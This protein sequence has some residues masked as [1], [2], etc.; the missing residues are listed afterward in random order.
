MPKWLKKAAAV[1]A[2]AV[3]AVAAAVVISAVAPAA[4][5]SLTIMAMN[6]GASYAVAHVAA[7]TVVAATSVAATAYAADDAYAA[8][9]GESI[10]LDTVFAGNVEAYNTGRDI[11]TISTAGMLSAAS[12]SP[13]VCFVDG[14]AVL[15]D[16]G[17]VNI[18][19]IAPGDMVWAWN[20]ET[21]EV[22]LKEVIETY[23][24]QTGE[25]VHIF[26]N[27]EEIVCTPSHPFYSPVKG[28]TDAVHLRAGDILVL[29]NGEYVVIEKVQ[30]EIL[31]EPIAVY[32]FQVEDFHTYYVSDVGVLVHNMCAKKADIKQVKN[33]ARE[34]GIPPEL[35]HDFG[36]YVEASKWG[37]PKNFTYSYAKLLE[38]AKEFL[39]EVS[40]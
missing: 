38:L 39:E 7:V 15:T 25:L 29:V 5:C 24:N 19:D 11:V 27:G 9:S 40:K 1:A 28:W 33:A 18:K 14:T 17:E 10:L 13:G 32:N 4:V 34:V 26:V 30:H 23:V 8:V 12:V 6:C 22:A 21:G 37:Y 20:E 36:D 2:A 3:V 35:I 16:R 31:E